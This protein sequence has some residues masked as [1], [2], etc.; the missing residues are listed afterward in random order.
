MF[1]KKILRQIK[2][3]D[4]EKAASTC[5][6]FREPETYVDEIVQLEFV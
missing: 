5:G 2:L 3:G 1:E 4:Y 6:L